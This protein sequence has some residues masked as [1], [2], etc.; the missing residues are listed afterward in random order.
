MSLPL[1][2]GPYRTVS[3][4]LAVNLPFRDTPEFILGSGEW[5]GHR[6]S[7]GYGWTLIIGAVQH[8]EAQYVR[9]QNLTQLETVGDTFLLG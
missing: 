6:Y 3:R 9:P 4:G 5:R 1:P 2:Q 7:C 8:P